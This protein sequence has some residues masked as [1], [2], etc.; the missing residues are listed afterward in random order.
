MSEPIL[1]GTGIMFGVPKLSKPLC[2]ERIPKDAKIRFRFRTHTFPEVFIRTHTGIEKWFLQDKGDYWSL[3]FK[4]GEN[5][6]L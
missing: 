6:R 4:N 5:R 3:G 1:I 2:D